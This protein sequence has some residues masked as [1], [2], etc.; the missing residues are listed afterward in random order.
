MANVY[1]SHFYHLKSP[2]LSSL[3]VM[4]GELGRLKGETEN[5]L[6][7]FHLSP[8]ETTG[9]ALRSSVRRIRP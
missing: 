5:D 7:I 6:S 3:L 4:F 8:S 9:K 1:P 2:L